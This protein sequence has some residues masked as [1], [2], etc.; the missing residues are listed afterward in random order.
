MKTREFEIS[1]MSELGKI[2]RMVRK[3][4]GLTQRDA[5]ALCNVSMPFLNALERGKETAQMGKVLSVC[6]QLGISLQL[7]LPGEIP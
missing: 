1:S 3:E 5:A 4:A 6:N 7:R 2:V